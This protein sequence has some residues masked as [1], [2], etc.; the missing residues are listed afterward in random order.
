MGFEPVTSGCWC[1]ALSYE[2]T[3]VGGWSCVG[4]NVP[5]MNDQRLN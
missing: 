3:D 5:V 1:D 4:S 2:T